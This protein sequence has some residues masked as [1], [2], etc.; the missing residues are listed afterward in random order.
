MEPCTSYVGF[1][2]QK[3]G[4]TAERGWQTAV[5]ALIIYGFLDAEDIPSADVFAS[6]QSVYDFLREAGKRKDFSVEVTG[7]NFSVASHGTIYAWLY[8]PYT[9]AD[10]NLTT[11]AVDGSGRH[12]TIML[13][14]SGEKYKRTDRKSPVQY[15]AIAE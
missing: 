6:F 12:V 8:R 4:K 15:A 7:R 10:G 11:V 3:E 5:S 2:V 13:H 9:D 14:R 1:K